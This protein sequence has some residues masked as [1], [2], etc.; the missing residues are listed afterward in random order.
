MNIT[1]DF[2]TDDAPRLISIEARTASMAATDDVTAIEERRL[3]LL[4][5]L[6]EQ[7][8]ELQ[9]RMENN[10]A[11]AMREAFSFKARLSAIQFQ[12]DVETVQAVALRR[13]LTTEDKAMFDSAAQSDFWR[14]Q[15]LREIKDFLNSFRERLNA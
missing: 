10:D 13:N 4:T 7:E 2:G 15:D 6:V 12:S 11:N 5:P 14:R 1:L 3:S 8:K 9:V